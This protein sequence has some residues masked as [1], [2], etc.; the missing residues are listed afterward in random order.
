VI[1][2][3]KHPD[4]VGSL[5][6]VVAL[7][8][9]AAAYAG[10]ED[11]PDIG[12]DP[13]L[14]PLVDGDDVF[15]LRVVATPGHTPGHIAVL[16]PLGGLL[17]A[18]DALTVVDG[19]LTGPNPEFTPDMATAMESVAKLADLDLR[20]ILVGHGDPVTGDDLGARLRAMA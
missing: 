12:A 10:A 11:I 9:D 17:V 4:H 6:A 19:R 15:G 5:G 16:D 7:A 1:L 8:P 18:G 3:H 20:T 14:S 2:T 13:A